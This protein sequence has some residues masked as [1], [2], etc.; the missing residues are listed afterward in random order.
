MPDVFFFFF[1]FF[2]RGAKMVIFITWWFSR[3]SKSLLGKTVLFWRGLKIY[4]TFDG[5]IKWWMSQKNRQH[6][7]QSLFLTLVRIYR[8]I[9]W[10]QYVIGRPQWS[11][12]K[13]YEYLPSSNS[14]SLI[15]YQTIFHTAIW[16]GDHHC[17][18]YSMAGSQGWK[19]TRPV[20]SSDTYCVK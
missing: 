13:Q 20:Q 3:C 14:S 10:P 18:Y 9:Q 1:F 17:Y 15:P 8:N 16:T 11:W 6:F 19:Q 2:N 12:I 5:G 7:A 4:F